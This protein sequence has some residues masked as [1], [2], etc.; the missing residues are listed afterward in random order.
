MMNRSFNALLSYL[1]PSD[2]EYMIVPQYK[3]PGESRSI[4]FTYLRY[5]IPREAYLLHGDQAF[6]AFSASICGQP[7]AGEG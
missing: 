6:R 2:E 5:R 3:C 4:D 7:D 1:F